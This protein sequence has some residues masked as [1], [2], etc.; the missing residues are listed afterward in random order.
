MSNLKCLTTVILFG[1]CVTPSVKT[2]FCKNSPGKC[3]PNSKCKDEEG[4]QCKDGYEFVGLNCIKAVNKKV[5][6]PCYQRYS[7][8]YVCDHKQH[9]YCGERKCVCFD[10]FLPN[11]TS[12]RCEPEADFL[13]ASNLTKYIVLHGEYCYSNSNCIEGLEC[14]KHACSCPSPCVYKKGMQVCDCGAS[15]SIGPILVGILGGLLIIAFWSWTIT[16][17]WRRHTKKQAY[18]DASA[19]PS[20]QRSTA[21]YPLAPVTSSVPAA[22]LLSQEEPLGFQS[23]A[24]SQYSSSQ[25]FPSNAYN[26]AYLPNVSGYPSAPSYPPTLP[27]PPYSATTYDPPY[28][29]SSLPPPY[30]ADIPSHP[31]PSMPPS[32]S[33]APYPLNP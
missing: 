22:P 15:T 17:T 31:P 12:G 14:S 19:P 24:K 4:C 3:P 9:S 27:P 8:A 21:S 18:Q 32:S 20:V 29:P 1:L 7:I 23:P 28:A 11:V 33:S 25:G 5:M 10:A 16:I 2:R 13:R 30:P 26:D 6:E